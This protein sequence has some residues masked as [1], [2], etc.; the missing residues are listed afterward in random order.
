MVPA[1]G[2]LV[3][4]CLST[5]LARRSEWSRPLPFSCGMSEKT[6]VKRSFYAGVALGALVAIG[7]GFGLALLPTTPTWALLRLARAADAHDTD[8]IVELVDVPALA[9]R[10]LSELSSNPTEIL[11]SANPAR[12]ASQAVLALLGGGRL[13]TVLDAPELALRVGPLDLLR[14]WWN[15]RRSGDEAVLTLLAGAQPIDVVLRENGPG[16]WR[17]VGISPLTA[18]L[19]VSVPADTMPRSR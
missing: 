7:M 16:G 6:C 12:D 4:G 15:M 19:E 9:L 1:P 8:A 3:L 18:L 14:A 5:L 10:T 13:G 17:I 2:L 11:G